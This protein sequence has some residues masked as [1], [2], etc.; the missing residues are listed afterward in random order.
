[1]NESNIE[2]E[3]LSLLQRLMSDRARKA[4]QI[5]K[6]SKELVK[7]DDVISALKGRVGKGV[8]KEDGYG[9]KA[10]L[11]R[12]AINK[13]QKVQFTQADVEA[14]IQAINPSVEINRDRIRTVLWTMANKTKAINLVTKGNNR[15]LAVYAKIQDRPPEQNGSSKPDEQNEFDTEK[16]KRLLKFVQPIRIK[17]LASETGTNEE[18]LQKI[19]TG[20]PND[21]EMKGRGWWSVKS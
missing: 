10:E 16:I 11:V 6:L 17:G 5:D 18:A 15:Q 13:I 14:A 9:A 20:H 19:L 1:M 12:D 7:D 4:E 8:A 3:M 2:Q 21:F